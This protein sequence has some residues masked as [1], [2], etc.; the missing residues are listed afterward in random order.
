MKKIVLQKNVLSGKPIF[1]GTRIPVELVLEYLS[2]GNSVDD[3]LKEY[4]S[5]EKDD[6]YGAIQYAAQ[7]LKDHK[8]YPANQ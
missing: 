2:Q 8:M 5:L 7:I 6:I 1:E 3:I 4:P